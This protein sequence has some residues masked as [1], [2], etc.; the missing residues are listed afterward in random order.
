MRLRLLLTGLS[1][2]ILV[3]PVTAHAYLTPEQVLLQDAFLH[4]FSPP[5]STRQT[6]TRRDLQQETSAE[7]RAR[8]QAEY[9]A[10]QRPA[11]P[12]FA[13][14]D[15]EDVRPAASDE[16][17]ALLLQLQ[18]SLD[19]LSG[20]EKTPDQLRE[21]RLLERIAARQGEILRGAA[22]D[23]KGVLEGKGKGLTDTGP[24]LFAALGVLLAAAGWTLFRVRSAEVKNT[25]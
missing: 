9:F 16:V 13:A 8:E 11:E 14:A 7:R 10:A 20:E 19:E 23:G 24:G 21:E 4:G 25:L 22:D 6:E 5:P 1:L 15:E 12:T 3:A 2:L 17:E 18:A